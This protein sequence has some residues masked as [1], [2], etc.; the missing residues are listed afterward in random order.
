ML[1]LL[2]RIGLSSKMVITGD[3][4]QSDKSNDNGLKDFINRIEE[5]KD[6]NN[7]YLIKMDKNDV[8]RSDLV[9]EVLS[10]YNKQNKVKNIY[11]N[12]I[13]FENL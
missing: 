6:T 12:Y 10:L 1:M 5:R 7:I 9:N 11:K 13:D 8:Q 2:T 4:E 3:L